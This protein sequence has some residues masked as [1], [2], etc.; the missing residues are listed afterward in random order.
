MTGSVDYT[1]GDITFEFTA[2]PTLPV[3]IAW[4]TRKINVFF[5]TEYLPLEP[6]RVWWWVGYRGPTGTQPD[7]ADLNVFDDG[8]GNM[9]GDAI[10]GGTVNYETGEIEV[11]LN[12]NP[13]PTTPTLVGYA[14][15]LQAPDGVTRTFDFEVFDMPGGVGG[16]GAAVDLRE[17]GVDGEGR[18]RFRMTDLATP[19]V[20]LQDAWDN[21]Q[22][23][24]H[25]PTLDTEGDNTLSY[26]PGGA[27][28]TAFGR[29]TFTV[30]P[31]ATATRDIPVYVTAVGVG[32]YSA[33]AFLVKTPGG[34]GLD[35]Y[36]FADNNG[37]LW[38]TQVNTYPT[39]RLDHLRGRYLATL[40]G[41]PIA[42][43][44]S[45][46]LTYDAFIRVPPH[47]DVPIQDDQVA[48]ISQIRLVERAP[49]VVGLV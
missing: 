48:A 13:P 44:R 34:P 6:G 12:A 7:G 30:A 8:A 25:G 23:G 21:W 35:K 18:T 49:E 37:R 3:R 14:Y 33:W 46:R 45:L 20:S 47:L 15:L 17:G 24:L 41:S 4:T 40:S 9:V 26:T 32:M 2:A 43:G 27:N 16:G 39:D 31:A 29:V 1:T 22:G 36:L 5:P 28:T 10:V 19:G 38:G 11:E 42:S